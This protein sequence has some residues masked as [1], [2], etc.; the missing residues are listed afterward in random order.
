MLYIITGPAGVGKSTISKRLATLKEKS[1]LIE[2]DDI[3]GQV[4]G[5]YVSAWKEGN[6]LK[7]FWKIC[8]DMINTYLEEGYDV[9]FN[10]IVTPE[11]LKLL[12]EKFSSFKFVILITDE[13]ELLKRDLL[14]PEDCRMRERCVVLLNNFKNNDYEND[15]TLDITN[16]SVDGVIEHLENDDKFNI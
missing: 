3:Y 14:R 1:V 13:D 7:V 12:K 11:N 8:I 4:I 5:S 6:H 15:Y 10:Y 2:G 16:L 9:V